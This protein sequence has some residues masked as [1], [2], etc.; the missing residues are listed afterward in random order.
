MND[1]I[2]ARTRIETLDTNRARIRYVNAY[3]EARDRTFIARPGR[4]VYELRNDG[5]TTQPC[6]RLA[7]TGNTLIW[8]AA[9]FPTLAALIRREY[10]RLRSA[11]RSE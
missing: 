4:Y 10:R 3:G 2:T 7:S 11:E 6:E 9:R 5:S 1:T 8:N